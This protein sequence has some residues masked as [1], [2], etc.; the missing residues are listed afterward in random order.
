M[1][2]CS[3]A[4]GVAAGNRFIA[5]VCDQPLLCATP[6]PSNP[7]FVCIISK[8]K[9]NTQLTNEDTLRCLRA[10]PAARV[11]ELA[12]SVGTGFNSIRGV[13]DGKLLT[14]F[15]SQL[16]L[17]KD[18]VNKVPVLWGH[19]RDDSFVPLCPF[20]PDWFNIT[21]GIYNDRAKLRFD[22]V[23]SVGSLS[24]VSFT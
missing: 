22:E 7:W 17:N 12:A 16:L 3:L 6:F 9:C 11:L 13:I 4:E 2:D 19:N 20:V 15:P 10:V 21:E 18:I 14:D 24:M 8:A 23:S 5:A 1:S